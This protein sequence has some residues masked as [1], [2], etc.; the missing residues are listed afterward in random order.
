MS[1]ED[2]PARS[3]SKSADTAAEEG[4]NPEPMAEDATATSAE[5]PE[6]A[7]NAAEEGDPAPSGLAVAESAER[8]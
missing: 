5:D 4:G 1:V 7:A 6:V 3:P 2:P 8:A